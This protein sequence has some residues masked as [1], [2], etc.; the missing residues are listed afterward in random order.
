MFQAA[1]TVFSNS[2]PRITHGEP[3]FWKLDFY[4]FLAHQSRFEVNGAQIR[5]P[6]PWKPILIMIK[7]RNTASVTEKCGFNF[8]PIRTRT[9]GQTINAVKTYPFRTEKK[10]MFCRK[11]KVDFELNSTFNLKLN[12]TF[13]F[14]LKSWIQLFNFELSW[15]INLTPNQLKLATPNSNTDWFE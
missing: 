6:R 9:K 1:P 10:N 13:N 8:R 7:T 11:L 5:V 15:L 12:S 14:E 3:F 2:P 4:W